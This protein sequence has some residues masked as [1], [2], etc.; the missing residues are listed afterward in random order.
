[1][2]TSDPNKRVRVAWSLVGIPPT[3]TVAVPR[4]DLKL[5][6]SYYEGEKNA[7]IEYEL[8]Y[9]IESSN[10]ITYLVPTVKAHRKTVVWLLAYL[11][12]IKFS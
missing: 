10:N 11:H 9:G 7:R 2:L 8:S 6:M 1:M 3:T 5:I 12:N 4:S